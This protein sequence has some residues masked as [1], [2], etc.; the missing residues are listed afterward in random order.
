VDRP[1]GRLAEYL[2]ARGLLTATQ[3][4][5]ALEMQREH[6]DRR[7]VDILVDMRVMTQA[8]IQAVFPKVA[9][10]ECVVDKELTHFADSMVH[11]KFASATDI[12]REG[13]LGTRAYIL[14]SGKVF[15]WKRAEL[16]SGRIPLAAFGP[17]ELFG[18]M[19]LLD[20]GLRSATAVATE[21]S[22]V[23]V[24]TREDFMAQIKR[25]HQVT[26]DVFSLLI[27][28]LRAAD[29]LI[30]SLTADL[31]YKKVSDFESEV[32]QEAARAA[33]EGI[34]FEE[35]PAEEP[36]FLGV[37]FKSDLAQGL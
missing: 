28:R 10:F 35:T 17:G 32:V 25:D 5:Q 34:G 15:L 11:E 9:L 4:E 33:L 20:G 27:R 36:R 29:Q 24:L 12:F 18:E 19:A 37:E 3:V 31:L 22:E 8:A 23:M 7:F 14:L 1:G 6:P 30:A 26:L 16:D 21:P 2:I 13:E